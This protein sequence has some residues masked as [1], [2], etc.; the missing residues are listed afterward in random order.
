MK[1]IRGLP[2]D[3]KVLSNLILTIGNFDGVH[4]GH[5]SIFKKLIQRATELKCMSAVLTFDP[6]PSKILHPP[7]PILL[8]THLTAKMRLLE[9]LG[10]QIVICIDFTPE[11][12]RLTK[13]EFVEEFLIQS[14]EIKELFVGHDFAFGYQ[15]EGTIKYLQVI[16]KKRGFIVNV[17]E[18][19]VINDAI[20][21]SSLIR[22]LLQEGAVSQASTML[23]RKHKVKGLVVQGH[24]VGKKIG[25]PTANLRC[26]NA[27]IPGP[28][29]YAVKAL[30][31]KKKFVGV[32]NIGTCPTFDREELSL[33]VH[34]LHFHQ[35]IYDEMLEI[36]FYERL[37]EERR[38]ESPE[39]LAEQIK[40]D[41]EQT[42]KIVPI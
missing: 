4:L 16:G 19:I 11:I 37:R 17:V 13:E 28:G 34:I 40:K 8:L 24:K 42:E 33:E 38:F 15:R 27:L 36:E 1:I 10:I 20:V 23:G 30:Y 25:F 39:A 32:V 12:A 7:T 35:E 14:L 41:I 18:P 2:K 3:K 31:G 5:Q 21:S 29:I 9:D 26:S 22:R 6:H